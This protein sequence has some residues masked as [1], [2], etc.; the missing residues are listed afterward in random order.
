MARLHYLY[1]Q[2]GIGRTRFV[3]Y[4]SNCNCVLLIRRDLKSQSEA[5]EPFHGRCFGCE[6]E[7]EGNIGCKLV[8]VP[9][10]WSDV[11]SA[12]D[13]TTTKTK[14]PQSLF[15][16]ASS[17]PHFSLGFP[18]LDSLMRPLSPNHLIVLNGDKASAVAELMTLRAQLPLEAGGL[19]S[20][21]FFIDGGN[22]SDPYL[23][24]TFAKQRGLKPVIAMRRVV[25]CRVFTIYQ[26][27]DLISG[28]LS[29]VIEDYA[30]KLV[31]ISDLLGTFNEPELEEREAS[32]LLNAIGGGIEQAKKHSLV[33]TTLVSP[34]KHDNTIMAWADVAIS[35]SSSRNRV[36]AELL[37]H[38]NRSPTVFSFTP[39]QFLK[40]TNI[41]AFS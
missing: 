39:S 2:E 7:L 25:T 21:V 35:M 1:E 28:H 13:A 29:S 10:A 5:I 37:K 23:F 34:N 22:R 11:V 18:R 38:P 6:C 20:A 12:T 16:S 40:S 24:S 26:L 31:V 8:P 33:L 36:R 32:R 4:C 15:R 30:T 3:Y 17:F 27:A 14:I 41:G 19:D 9:D